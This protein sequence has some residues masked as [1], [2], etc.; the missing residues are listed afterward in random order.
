MKSSAVITKPSTISYGIP[1]ESI[2][3]T[4]NSSMSPT[5]TK[6]EKLS[7]NAMLFSICVAVIV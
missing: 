2:P 5:E 1:L 3:V 4:I 7:E 6:T